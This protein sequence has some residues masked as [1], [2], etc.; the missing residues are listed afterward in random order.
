MHVMFLDES[1]AARAP[2]GEALLRH[3]A[4]DWE[5]SS[6]GWSS[7]HV[8]PEVKRVLEEAGVRTDGLLSRR[9][10]PAAMEGVDVLISFVPDEGRVRLP[11]GARR[12]DWGLPDPLAAP[13]EERAEAFRATRDEIERR[14]KRL[15]AE[16]R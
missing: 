8:R 15:V 2:M 6:A 16:A 10:H 13:L 14:L 7:S 1:G 5:V 11:A 3:L 9:L 12:L 4:P